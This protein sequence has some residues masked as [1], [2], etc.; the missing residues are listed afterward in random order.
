[1]DAKSALM[2]ISLQKNSGFVKNLLT[3]SNPIVAKPLF[4]CSEMVT[5]AQNW[6][7]KISLRCRIGTVRVIKKEKK[8]GSNF[9]Q[10][11]A[12]FGV[13]N[14]QQRLHRAKQKIDWAPVPILS[15]LK[16]KNSD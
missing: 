12:L 9:P 16:L 5:N 6:D 13:K 4:F 15:H 11:L 3:I 2:T 10:V 7:T 1:M 8:S 14:S